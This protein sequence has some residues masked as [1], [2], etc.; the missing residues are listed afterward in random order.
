MFTRAYVRQA[1]FVRR[2]AAVGRAGAVVG[3]L[4]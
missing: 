1:E 2:L 4:G 3:G